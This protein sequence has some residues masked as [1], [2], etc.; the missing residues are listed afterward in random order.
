MDKLNSMQVFVHVVDTHS[1]ARASEILGL[2]RS[3]VSRV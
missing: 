1:F 3:T 2:P